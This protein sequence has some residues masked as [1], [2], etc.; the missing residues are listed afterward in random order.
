M[1]KGRPHAPAP[2]FPA[3]LAAVGPARAACRSQ[4]DGAARRWRRR[5]R[6]GGGAGLEVEVN[7][8][9]RGGRPHPRGRAG[10]RGGRGGRPPPA[11]L[12]LALR[13]EVQPLQRVGVGAE[14]G[15]G[16]EAGVAPAP[17]RRVQLR[18]AGGV[19]RP[20]PDHRGVR[21]R[22]G[23]RLDARRAR[24]ERALAHGLLAED[25]VHAH[26]DDE[27]ADGVDGDPP[28]LQ[29]LHVHED[30]GTGDAAGHNHGAFVDRDHEECLILTQSPRHVDHV[31]EGKECS[32][33]EQHVGEP[34]EPNLPL[35]LVDGPLDELDR[36]LDAEH[37]PR[38]R[39]SGAAQ[40]HAPDRA[41]AGLGHQHKVVEEEPSDEDAEVDE[42]A[43]VYQRVL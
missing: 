22:R 36:A 23:Q 10:G 9:G 29:T 18:A 37:I 31:G 27:D 4:R 25:D 19:Q 41:A 35:R 6:R 15:G 2:P 17:G 16:G 21:A 40:G 32:P 33:H 30:H 42:H 14:R 34:M 12:V 38:D 26:H 3:S 24:H 13:V 7:V 28:G 1:G 43:Y 39:P 5:R 11:L 8:G 20:L